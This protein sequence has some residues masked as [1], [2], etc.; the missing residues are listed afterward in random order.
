MIET[1]VV[2][3]HV[4]FG[5]IV[6]SFLNVVIFRL[7]TGKSLRGRS[8]CMSCG[9]MLK[10]LHLVP[11]FSFLCLRMRCYFCRARISGRY[12]L[13]EL[14]TGLLF[15]LT[16]IIV[17][18]ILLRV[19]LLALMA[20]LVVIVVYDLLHTIIP[21]EYVLIASG[22]ALLMGLLEIAYA[23]S[24]EGALSHALGALVGFL[25]FASLWAVSKGRWVGL[26]DAKLALPLGFILGWPGI[27][28]CIILSFWIGAGISLVLLG[29]QKVVKKGRLRVP[30]LSS[31]LTIKSEIPFA[32]FLIL[33]FLLVYFFGVDVFMLVGSGVTLLMNTFGFLG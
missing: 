23:H 4:L 16:A 25:F 28:S 27:V 21:D 12:F 6:G 33:G 8:H 29:A 15:G 9:R 7:H 3:W 20:T 14:L 2:L 5:F 26:G 10:W 17:S 30:F 19:L 22:I 31:S 13:V 1:I 24:W 11:V 32:P 18:D